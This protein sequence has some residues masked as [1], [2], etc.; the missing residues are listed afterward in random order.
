M[1]DSKPCPT[2]K[3]WIAEPDNWNWQSCG[4]FTAAEDPC[5]K[6][7]RRFAEDYAGYLRN[8]YPCAFVAVRQADKKLPLPVHS[9]DDCQDYDSKGD[10]SSSWLGQ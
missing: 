7:A 8:T 2:Y 6:G 10:F 4:T 9:P 1:T 3:V 5:G